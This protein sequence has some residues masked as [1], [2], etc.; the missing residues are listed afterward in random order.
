MERR[1]QAAH[2][3]IRK[4]ETHFL[5]RSEFGLQ[6]LYTVVPKYR[7]QLSKCSGQKQI[8][9]IPFQ[10]LCHPLRSYLLLLVP[11]DCAALAHPTGLALDMDYLASARITHWFKEVHS[12]S[13]LACRTKL[14]FQVGLCPERITPKIY[15]NFQGHRPF[16]HLSWVFRSVIQMGQLVFKQ[17]ANIVSSFQCSSLL[18]WR[19]LLIEIGRT[20]FMLHS[21]L[22]VTA[23]LNHTLGIFP[24]NL[25]QNRLPCLIHHRTGTTI[26]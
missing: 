22:K 21:D 11:W 26:S 25:S 14:C 10:K 15:I 6:A 3:K 9:H 17:E 16:N 24:R 7:V 23:H 2:V 8:L 13:T 19:G 1:Y 4:Q 18:L 20:S 5:V 12:S